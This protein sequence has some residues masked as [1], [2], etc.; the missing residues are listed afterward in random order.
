MKL[1][2]YLLTGIVFLSPLASRGAE[3][4]QTTIYCYSLQFQ[5]GLDPNGNYYL[6]LTSL[7]GSLN[8]ELAPDF[9]AS[10][11]THSTYL[12]L[13]DE[14]LGSTLSGK[15]AL[16]VPSGGDANGDGFPDFFQVSQ[17]ITNLAS[18]GVYFDLQIYGN[19]TV[20]ALWNR[21]AGSN[22]GTCVLTMQLMPFQPVRFSHPFELLEYRGPLSY[23]TTTTNVNGRLNLGQTGNAAAS[24][25]EPIQFVKSPTNRFNE[26]TLQ[27]GIWTN[28]SQQAMSYVEHILTRDPPWPTNYY[29]YLEFTD[30]ATSGAFYPYGLWM[31]SIDDTNDANHNGIPD[32]SDD[33][34]P[35]LPRAPEL[36]L[37]QTT[38]NL[39]LTLHG[40]V[41]HL[42]EIQ[43]LSD[44]SSTGWQTAASLTITNDPQ[45]VSIPLP[46][47]STTFWRARA[48]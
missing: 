28:E 23:T 36:E 16:D 33:P 32:F 19:G 22:Y 35:A 26:L 37:A 6:N 29:G 3:Q 21:A 43:K 24:L 38:T 41:G 31:L 45:Q 42:L 4:A 27:P 8:G 11:Y 44:L 40:D 12:S 2:R 30:T 1:V 15:M 7:S 39:L 17:G 34:S 18:S 5:Q 46:T 13:V 47:E 48:R 20:T 25:N 9:F 14:L 10:G